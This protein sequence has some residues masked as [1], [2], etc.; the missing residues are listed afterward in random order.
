MWR[1]IWVLA[2]CYVPPAHPVVG[3]PVICVVT[4]AGLS[5]TVTNRTGKNTEICAQPYVGVRATG[6]I[7]TTHQR[8]CSDPLAPGDTETFPV[9][10]DFRPAGRCGAGL[11]GCTVSVFG[12]GDS[13]VPASEVVAFAR[14][15]QTKAHAVSGDQPTVRECEATIAT[16]L[17]NPRFAAYAPYREHPDDLTLFCLGL[18]RATLACLQ[19]AEDSTQ[20]DACAP[21]HLE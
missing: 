21:Q 2:A 20:A 14:E 13:P 5:C 16:W 12:A 10:L 1:S 4:A 19:A 15:L 18:P 3:P 6:A 8:V 17:D 7:Y 9:T 11:D